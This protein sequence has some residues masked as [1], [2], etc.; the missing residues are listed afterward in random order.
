MRGFLQFHTRESSYNG[1]IE[2][3]K[4]QDIMMK[5]YEQFT[6]THQTWHEVCQGMLGKFFKDSV[7]SL[8]CGPSSN[9]QLTHRTITHNFREDE[10]QGQ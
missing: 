2:T 9:V 8:N 1:S 6:Q 4:W 5:A 3:I 7:S 10:E